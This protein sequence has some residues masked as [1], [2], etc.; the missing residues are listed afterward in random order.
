MALFQSPWKPSMMDKWVRTFVIP[1]TTCVGILLPGLCILLS[2]LGP[3]HALWAS[4]F[5]LLGG[6]PI[7]ILTPSQEES[8]RQYQAS[9][10]AFEAAKRDMPP[11]LAHVPL[12]SPAVE[13]KYVDHRGTNCI[14]IVITSWFS[15]LLFSNLLFNNIVTPV[16]WLW[17]MM[18]HNIVNALAVV[19]GA[20]AGTW[21]K[22]VLTPFYTHVHM[23]VRR[24]ISQLKLPF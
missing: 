7:G 1:V 15:Y 21:I 10:D 12:E 17:M 8:R 24:W 14:L 20:Y 2:V 9:I 22:P 16:Q 5:F 3:D 19:I 11:E 6:V 23:H 18:T 13:D 4:V